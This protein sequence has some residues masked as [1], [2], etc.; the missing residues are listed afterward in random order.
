MTCDKTILCECYANK[1]IASIALG[2]LMC[3]RHK[4]Y[5]GRDTIIEEIKILAEKARLGSIYMAVIDKEYGGSVFIDEV[6][7]RGERIDIVQSKIYICNSIYKNIEVVFI[8][9]DPNVEEAFL[10][11][12][13]KRICN[14]YRYKEIV[15]SE[16]GE[17]YIQ[18]LLNRSIKNRKQVKE[19]ISKITSS[20]NE[21]MRKR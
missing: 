2:D 21:I 19:I 20:I 11:D 8:I 5:M 18:R 1:A 17:K 12:L 15:K 10:C 14:D 13:D 3:I 6:C 9:F 16:K 4:R 7:R